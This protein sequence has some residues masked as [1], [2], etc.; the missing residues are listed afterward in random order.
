[1]MSAITISCLIL[2]VVAPLINSFITPGQPPG[3]ASLMLSDVSNAKL[4]NLKNC[5]VRSRIECLIVC[6]R[7]PDSFVI[8]WLPSSN[9]SKNCFCQRQIGTLRLKTNIGARI[10]QMMYGKLCFHIHSIHFSNPICNPIQYPSIRSWFFQ[11]KFI[12]H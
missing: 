3:W 6:H 4:K 1:M 11:W 2:V 7:V 8:T 9:E 10:Y 5:T 12:Y